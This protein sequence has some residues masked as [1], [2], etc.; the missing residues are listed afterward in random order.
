M[1]INTITVHQCTLDG[2]DKDD[3]ALVQALMQSEK[4]VIFK[5]T[6]LTL[7]NQYTQRDMY[8]WLFNGEH[9][10][11]KQPKKKT[12]INRIVAYFKAITT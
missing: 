2:T 4:R 7:W 6:Y 5:G 3:V 1:K 11:D 12:F 9:S 10:P 8:E